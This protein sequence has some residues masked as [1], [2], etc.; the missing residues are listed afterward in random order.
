MKVLSFEV[1]FYIMF[2]L[3]MVTTVLMAKE[4]YI[5]ITLLVIFLI[6]TVISASYTGWTLA[7]FFTGEISSIA[8]GYVLFWLFIPLQCA[9]IGF[10]M[11]KVHILSGR[12]DLKFLIILFGLVILITAVINMIN[13]TGIPVTLT[14]VCVGVFMLYAMISEFRLRKQYA[15]ETE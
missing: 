4:W 6:I 13:H 14:I 11:E 15:G 3:S 7:L 2:I 9:T 12:Q 5:Y 10:F 1:L 8:A